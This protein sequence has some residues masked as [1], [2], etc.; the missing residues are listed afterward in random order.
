[1]KK[2]IIL[3]IPL[4]LVC[5]ALATPPS[6]LPHAFYGTTTFNGAATPVD[7]VITATC[8]SLEENITV[9]IA[10]EYGGAGGNEDKLIVQNCSNGDTIT[11]SISVT[12]YTGTSTVTDTYEPGAVE[13][14]TLTF[15]GTATTTTTSGGG[16]GN[17]GAGT[18]TTTVVTTTTIPIEES[19][20][21]SIS[22]GE[23][24]TF[25][26]IKDVGITD[27][28]IDVENSV[29]DAKITIKTIDVD[30]DTCEGTLA[31][32]SA[33]GISYRE[34][35]LEKENI[36]N[37]DISTITIKFK[38]SKTWISENNIDPDTIALYRY[39]DGTWTKL[40]TTKTSEDS[41]YIYFE[42]E[43][44]GLSAFVISG[45]ALPTTTTT[46]STTTTTIPEKVKSLLYN[47]FLI[48]I[49]IVIVLIL[50]YKFVLK[51]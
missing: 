17:G 23:T 42:A 2:K 1:M 5:T 14:K 45:E 35:C 34:L 7:S 11:F 22:G 6:T 36:E 3:F 32:I 15:T 18:T 4:L 10:G 13:E 29:S 12:G 49:I 24:G 26:Y 38:V 21:Q 8:D 16:G 41:S 48:I 47:T 40:T 51:R 43:S 28:V 27:L 31:S 39:A 33:P 20:T 25:T 44:P 46:T 50:V 19:S 9:E 37:E 30:E